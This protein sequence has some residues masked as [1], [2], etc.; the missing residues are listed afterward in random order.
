VL[1]E[2]EDQGFRALLDAVRTQGVAYAAH[3]Q[4]VQ[5]AHY[6][7][8]ETG[9]FSYVHQPLRVAP[10]QP[11]AIACVAIEVTAQVVARQQVQRLNEELAAINGELLASNEEL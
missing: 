8:G 4:A 7:P 1:P 5:L 11:A 6:Q 10:G 9:Y 2:L 3:E